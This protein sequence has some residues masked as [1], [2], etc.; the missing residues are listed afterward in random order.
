MI[1]QH[2]M[3]TVPLYKISINDWDVKK[4]AVLDIIGDSNYY[5]DELSGNQL[6]DFNY[7]RHGLGREYNDYSK[8]M[9]ELLFPYIEPIIH[10]LGTELEPNFVPSMWSQKYYKFSRHD[11]HHHGQKGY[12]C[13]LYIKYNVD[14]HKPTRFLSPFNNFTS[15]STTW[16]SPDVREG[17]LILFPST[18]LH[19][20]PTQTTDEER[21]ILS[22]NL[23]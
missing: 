12:S 14:V 1:E 17:D 13:I 20:S 7:S 9:W 5:E 15:G 8:S 2:F 6:T 18:I 23:H 16:F 19:E 4:N 22:F 11:I 21:M 3:F 10:H